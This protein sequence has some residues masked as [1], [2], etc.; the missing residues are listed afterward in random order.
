MKAS[1]KSVLAYSHKWLEIIKEKQIPT[2]E[3]ANWI[4]EESLHNFHEHFNEWWL[5]YRKSVTLAGDHAAIEWKG[6]WSTIEDVYG[7]KYIDWLGG[8]GLLS[9]GWS[10]PEVIEAVQSQLLHNPMPSQELI[11][12]LRGVLARML[13]EITPGD[14]KY[15]WIVSSLKN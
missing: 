13:A 12:P 2:L 5:E 1:K 10:H 11:D 8:Y 9:H 14:L 15:A 3:E 7:R 6:R 4:A